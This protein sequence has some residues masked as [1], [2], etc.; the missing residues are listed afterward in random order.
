[1]PSMSAKHLS[2]YSQSY[3]YDLVNFRWDVVYEDGRHSSFI[4]T[5][6]VK[7]DAKRRGFIINA[8]YYDSLVGG[9][10]DLKKK[11]IRVADNSYQRFRED[12]L[13]MLRA[14]RFPEKFGFQN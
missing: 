7:E 8:I 2:L 3:Q 12:K 5:A 11:I 9:Q 6:T 13:R 4:K 1:M 14:I 10:E